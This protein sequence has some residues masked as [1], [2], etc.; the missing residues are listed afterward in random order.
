GKYS[1]ECAVARALGRTGSHD[2]IEPLITYATHRDRYV[3]REAANALSQA[4]WADTD[5][6]GVEALIKLTSDEDGEVRN[7]ATFALG[8][9]LAVDSHEVREALW[10][11]LSDPYDE[12]RAEGIRG[13]AR[14]RDKRAI[15]YVA[16]LL[17]AGEAHLFTFDAAGFLGAPELVPL[18]AL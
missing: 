7:R 9:Q 4:M 1:D 15:P 3:R 17:A 14:R 10:Q 6:V 11:R 5:D 18:L 16:D 12:A 13:L 8:W 2:A